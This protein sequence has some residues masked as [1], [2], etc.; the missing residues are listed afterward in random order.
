MKSYN[1]SNIKRHDDSNSHQL[2]DYINKKEFS[3]EISWIGWNIYLYILDW[4]KI[5]S[6]RLVPIY[7]LGLV[8]GLDSS[9]LSWIWDQQAGTCYEGWIPHFSVGYE[10]YKM[11]LS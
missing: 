1:G 2:E 5:H 11:G 6:I 3:E 4:M 10:N 8:W 9:H 7:K